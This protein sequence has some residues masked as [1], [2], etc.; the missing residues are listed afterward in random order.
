MRR[1][2]NGFTPL[3]P[4]ILLPLNVTAVTTA[5]TKCKRAGI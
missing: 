5:A 2:H 1:A 4:H 3:T